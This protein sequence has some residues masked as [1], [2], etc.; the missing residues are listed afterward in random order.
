MRSTSTDSAAGDRTSRG[1]GVV[2]GLTFLAAVVY[3][4]SLG[5]ERFT[6]ALGA[7][8]VGAFAVVLALIVATVLKEAAKRNGRGRY[9]ARRLDSSNESF[10]VSRVDAFRKEV[11]RLEK[12]NGEFYEQSVAEA[13][14]RFPDLVRAARQALE[15]VSRR[16]AGCL[17]P[18]S[19]NEE[20]A[21]ERFR[22]AILAQWSDVKS[23]LGYAAFGEF[24]ARLLIVRDAWQERAKIVGRRSR[25]AKLEED[26]A[27]E[28][29]QVMANLLD[30]LRY[31]RLHL[32]RCELNDAQ[33]DYGAT[34]QERAR[35]WTNQTIFRCVIQLR[36]QGQEG[37]T[38]RDT[39]ARD[40]I[41]RLKRVLE[42]VTR[43]SDRLASNV[44]DSGDERV[45]LS[46]VVYGCVAMD[47]L[48]HLPEWFPEMGA[49]DEF[50][51]AKEAEDELPEVEAESA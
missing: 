37:A 42:L 17:R 21:Y 24:E 7:V 36:E 23:E 41:A 49:V 11:D 39:S 2:L 43:L 16:Y 10:V 14:K 40:R 48:A 12:E 19:G 45:A 51:E 32:L 20:A 3:A 38:I 33:R 4:A 9:A 1:L 30:A 13:K 44:A 8:A 46:R 5:V 34:F 50:G 26:A 15:R 28:R 35:E 29:A 47:A 25:L 6:Q 27:G 22:W 18:G 31:D